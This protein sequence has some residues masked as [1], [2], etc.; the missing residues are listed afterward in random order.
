MRDALKRS[1]RHAEAQTGLSVPGTEEL[2][3]MPTLRSLA[4]ICLVALAACAGGNWEKVRSED[5]A[6]AYRRFLQQNPRTPHAAEAQE[7]LAVLAFEQAP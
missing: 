2:R 1:G 6:S 7:R 5:T 4:V 3:R